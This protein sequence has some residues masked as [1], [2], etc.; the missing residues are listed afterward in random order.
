MV[1]GIIASL[2][3]L[4]DRAGGLEN[5]DWEAQR[6]VMVGELGVKAAIRPPPLPLAAPMLGVEFGIVM[7]SVKSIFFSQC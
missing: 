6:L 5:S 4:Q 3:S 2:G 7:T 1:I